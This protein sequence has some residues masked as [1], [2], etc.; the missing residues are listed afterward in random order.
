MLKVINY[1]IRPDCC[2][3]L[4]VQLALLVFLASLVVREPKERKETRDTLDFKEHRATKERGVYQDFLYVTLG[5]NLDFKLQ[6]LSKW[7]ANAAFTLL[8]AVV[9]L[10]MLC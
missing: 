1:Y 5:L 2:H 4:Q 10:K 8:C 3:C 9:S 7:T 6:L